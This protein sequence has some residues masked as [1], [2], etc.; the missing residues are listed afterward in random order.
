MTSALNNDELLRTANDALEERR[1]DANANGEG[2][3]HWSDGEED[4]DE[5][6]EELM[7]QSAWTNYR[8]LSNDRLGYFGRR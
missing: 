2:M 5:D 8:L 3:Y 6:D 4:D 1:R 7:R